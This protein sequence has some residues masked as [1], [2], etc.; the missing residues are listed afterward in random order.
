MIELIFLKLVNPNATLE[1]KSD[2]VNSFKLSGLCLL[3]RHVVIF[4][5]NTIEGYT[6]RTWT[7]NVNKYEEKKNE[8]LWNLFTFRPS[9]ASFLFSRT[10]FIQYWKTY[11]VIFQ[12]WKC[13]GKTNKSKMFGKVMVW[14]YLSVTYWKE[15][16]SNNN[17][18]I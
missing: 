9:S 6:N 1:N 10:G 5:W 14:Y 15:I 11:Q 8:N 7:T 16:F 13:L 17:L 12:V 4:D 18:L 2:L 3:R